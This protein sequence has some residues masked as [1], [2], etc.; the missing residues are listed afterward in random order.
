[1]NAIRIQYQLPKKSRKD[2]SRIRMKQARLFFEHCKENHIKH[3]WRL[4]R[5]WSGQDISKRAAQMWYTLWKEGKL[6]SMIETTD[7]KFYSS[8]ERRAQKKKTQRKED[9]KKKGI[10][11]GRRME[12]KKKERKK[13]RKQEN[14]KKREK[15]RKKE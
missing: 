6:N 12:K 11:R 14:R 4:L 1:M 15:E 5:R 10:E 3:G 9:R 7:E 2:K 8:F 13:E